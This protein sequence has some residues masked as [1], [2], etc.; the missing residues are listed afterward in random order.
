MFGM[1]T[2]KERYSKYREQIR[3]MREEDF[4]KGGHVDAEGSTAEAS[5][6][7]NPAEVSD[8][9]SI[10]SPYDLYLR[11]RYK[12]LAVKVVAL[13]LTIAGFVV[14]WVLMQGR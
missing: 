3:H 2:R 8:Q 4:P 1:E 6:A 5:A 12:M 7:H 14:W 9:S 10:L 13:V 11:H